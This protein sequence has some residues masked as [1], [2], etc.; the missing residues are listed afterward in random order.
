MATRINVLTKEVKQDIWDSISEHLN[1]AIRKSAKIIVFEQ[2]EV[3]LICIYLWDSE[4][5]SPRNVKILQQV[6]MLASMFNLPFICVGDFS[7]P[8]EAFNNSEWPEAF[9]A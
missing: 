5:F 1:S 6:Y 4:Q 3:L 8:F 7:I 2:L 9:R